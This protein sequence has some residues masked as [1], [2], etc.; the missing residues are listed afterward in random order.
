VI[1]RQVVEIAKSVKILAIVATEHLR[2]DPASVG[3][4]IPLLRKWPE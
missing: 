4:T 3:S 1:E 2:I